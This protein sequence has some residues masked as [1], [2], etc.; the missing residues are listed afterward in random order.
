MKTFIWNVFWIFKGWMTQEHVLQAHLRSFQI[1]RLSVVTHLHD[2][3][4][5]VCNAPVFVITHSLLH[6]KNQDQFKGICLREQKTET[7]VIHFL[8]N[9]FQCKHLYGILKVM[10]FFFFFFLIEPVNI[11]PPAYYSK[12]QSA[13]THNLCDKSKINVFLELKGVSVWR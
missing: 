9:P 13:K 7:K 5:Q 6:K 10:T 1:K 3:L 2:I 12:T 4:F 11:L 8:L